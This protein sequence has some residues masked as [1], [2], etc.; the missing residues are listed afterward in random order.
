MIGSKQIDK[1]IC[2]ACGE[3]IGIHSKNDLGRC[4]F[5]IQGT[6]ISVSRSNLINESKENYDE[7][8]KNNP[9]DAKGWYN[10][11][12][13]LCS[14]NRHAEAII[15]YDEAININPKLADV[16]YYKGAALHSLGRYEDAIICYDE[17]IKSNPRDTAACNN[18][19]K[20]L[21]Y[22]GKDDEAIKCYDQ[23]YYENQLDGQKV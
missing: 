4:L 16:W 10:K 15:C 9:T 5:R 21:E 1:I 11:G 18:K 14:L 22:L 2:I 17:A 6:F 20:A 13:A 12:F 23:A 8:I 3:K 7:V 19:A